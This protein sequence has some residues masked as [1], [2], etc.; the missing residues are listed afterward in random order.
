MTTTSFRIRIARSIV[1]TVA[2]VAFIVMQAAFAS[3]GGYTG[4]TL[5]SN[6]SG[7]GGCH[8]S[9]VSSAVSVVIAGPDT[10]TVGKAATYTMTIGGGP[11]KGAGCDIAAKYGTLAAVS[12]SLKLS[13]GELTQRSNTAMSNGSITYQFTYT[14]PASRTSDTLYGLGLSTNSNGG[15]S[16][17]SWNWSANKGIIIVAATDVENTAVAP[18]GI[19]LGAN[20][21]NPFGTQTEFHFSLDASAYATLKVYNLHGEE[22][23]TVV[24]G[25]TGRGE[26]SVRWNAGSLP[27]GIY[28]YRLQVGRNTLTR[29]LVVAR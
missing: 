16:G 24:D 6:K 27:N 12:S 8:G 22:M 25:V 7:C 13:S 17:D 2:T 29:K 26:H 10:V 18:S 14:A 4:R 5:K 23:A 19:T 21:P 3:P 20:A 15:T 1:Y 11:A 9:S 28:L